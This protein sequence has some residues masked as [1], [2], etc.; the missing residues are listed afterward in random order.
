MPYL[1]HLPKPNS[2]TANESPPVK[3]QLL[4]LLLLSKHIS[5]TASNILCNF[6]AID[7]DLVALLLCGRINIMK[8]IQP[9]NDKTIEEF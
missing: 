8:S 9:A 1:L 5:S 3:V 7:A 6:E 4:H 2:S